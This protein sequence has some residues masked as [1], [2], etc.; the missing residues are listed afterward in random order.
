MITFTKWF[1]LVF[2]I[3]TAFGGYMGYVKAG[4][5]ASLI[6]GSLCGLLLLVAFWLLPAPQNINAALIIGLV[7]SVV[8]LGQFLPKLLHHEL[9]P[10]IVLT[11]LLSA[12]SLTVT[13]VSWYKK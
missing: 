1:Y 7:V 10:H 11:T 6:A 5:K 3:L 2:G 9:K 12:V 13:I 8:L 4:S